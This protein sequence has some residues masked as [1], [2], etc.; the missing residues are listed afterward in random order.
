METTFRAILELLLNDPQA[1]P[2]DIQEL[3]NNRTFRANLLNK[4]KSGDSRLPRTTRN[5]WRDFE[6]LSPSEIKDRTAPILHRLTAF[7][8]T[9]HLE[10][11]SCHPKTIDYKSII[12]G[13]KM[14]LIDLS[15]A[16]V[17]NEVG[18]LGAIFFANFFLHSIGLGGIDDDANEPPRY[19]L[20]IDDARRFITSP[21]QDMFSEARKYGLAVTLASQ[22][23]RQFDS[24]TQAEINKNVSTRISFKSD[25]EDAGQIA[26][27]YK[28]EV[29]PEEIV[30]FGVGQAVVKTVVDG[31]DVS[32]FVVETYAPLSQQGRENGVDRKAVIAASRRNLGLLTAAEIEAFID[33]RYDGEMY[34]KPPETTGLTRFEADEDE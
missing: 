7:L 30:K 22:Y 2:L 16:K 24:A 6:N 10:L 33:N 31:K 34:V 13:K 25:Q 23:V 3:V 4:L 1:T 18:N 15:G 32:P 17:A 19:H 27:F 5:Y 26:R 11:M 14:V 28:P 12:A 21:L 8:G 9:G 29:S 20:F